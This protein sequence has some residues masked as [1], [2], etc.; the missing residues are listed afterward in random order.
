MMD[1]R[2]ENWL[3]YVR[4]TAQ[5]SLEFVEGLIREQFLKDT[6]NQQA[7][8]MNLLLIGST[9]KRIVE[10]QPSFADRHPDIAWKE[11]MSMRNRI[12]HEYDAID[13]NIVW[14][15]ITEDLPELIAQ[16]DDL[17]SQ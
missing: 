12:A 15:T 13:F 11:M 1:E 16:I 3:I 14:D 17:L 5:Q 8:A 10:R 4:E 6:R 2:I 9:A 7:C